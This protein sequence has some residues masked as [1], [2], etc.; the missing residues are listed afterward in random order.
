[1][2]SCFILHRVL[3]FPYDGNEPG[4]FLGDAA[5]RL[6]GELGATQ[7]TGLLGPFY[8]DALA[9][10][11]ASGNYG[12]LKVKFDVSRVWPVANEFRG[13]SLSVLYYIVY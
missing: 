3:N 7:Q 6:Y 9:D 12:F 4:T 2:V 5:R 13:A 10:N 11:M 8:A 1:V